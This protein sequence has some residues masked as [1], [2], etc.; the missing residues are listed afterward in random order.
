MFS[1]SK[2]NDNTTILFSNNLIVV[3]KIN[4]KIVFN[5]V[6]FSFKT[7][8]NQKLILD[9]FSSKFSFINFFYLIFMKRN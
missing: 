7:L 9:F 3:K 5:F 2:I 4:L 6:L 8:F 1:L